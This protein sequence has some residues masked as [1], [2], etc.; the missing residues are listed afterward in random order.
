FDADCVPRPD[1]LK[2][3]VPYLCEN[4][5]IG[6]VQAR[7]TYLNRNQSIL[8]RLQALI[9]DGL[10]VL[11]QPLK[12]VLG[13][14]FQFNGTAGIWRRSAIESSGGWRGDSIVEDADLSFRAWMVGWRFLHVDDVVV[15]TELPGTMGAFR[16][17]QRRWSR[18]KAQ[19]LRNM[20]LRL[21][22]APIP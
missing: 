15:P 5:A 22:S 12:S 3:M 9:L 2:R 21:W 18:G 14:P 8:T 16:A 7:W 17:Q 20:G 6:M 11:E 13:R 19:V 4:P 1:F 10:M